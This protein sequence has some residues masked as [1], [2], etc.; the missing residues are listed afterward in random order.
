M[1][2]RQ[3]EDRREKRVTPPVVLDSIRDA[4]GDV[5]DRWSSITN[6]MSFDA[7]LSF[8][9]Q[10]ISG[11]TYLASIAATNLE[12][13]KAA[14]LACG[15]IGVSLSPA[16]KQAY[17][18]PRDG[19]VMLDI[20]YLGLVD[21][22]VEDGLVQWVQASLVHES[23]EFKING[24]DKEPTHI[25]APFPAA[26]RGLVIG[27]Y[28]VA[29]TVNGDYL[30][31]VMSIEEV[32][33]IRDR[34]QAWKRFKSDGVKCPWNTDE[35][36]MIRKTVVKRGHKLWPRGDGRR[37]LEQALHYLNT[38]GEE[39]IDDDS[40]S[41]SNIPTKGEL[42]ASADAKALADAPKTSSFNA[43][44]WADQI[45]AARTSEAVQALWASASAEAKD[46][47]DPEG[48]KK[49]KIDHLLPRLDGIK[50]GRPPGV[51]REPG[52]DDEG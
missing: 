2:S 36:E 41:S 44:K 29:K 1:S 42:M 17:L 5:R 43:K 16:R 9:M 49:L 20:G 45:D 25:Y 37:R 47:N 38:D 27:A 28:C 40:S 32:Q 6:D 11:N 3:P 50:K 24:I 15:S 7:E 10:I 51:S 4:L 13:A 46:C 48:L 33:A 35:G 12:S 31:T 52:E 30:T 22:V 23:D 14:L 39:G 21:L 18:V 8:A 34:S 19:K 26:A